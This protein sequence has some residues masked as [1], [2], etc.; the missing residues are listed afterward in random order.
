VFTRSILTAGPALLASA[1]CWL[2][3]CVPAHAG[4]PHR[5]LALGDSDAFGFQFRSY[6]PGVPASTFTGYAAD[7]HAERPALALV[8]YGCV[9]ESTVSF[10]QGPC[11][12]KALG[13]QLHD[14]YTGSQLKAALAFLLTHPLR[15][16]LI[17]LTLWGNDVNTFVAGCAGDL[18]CVQAGAQA[19]IAKFSA[20]LT[21]I[22]ASL[23]IA[24]GPRATIVLTGPYDPN[25]QPLARLTHPLYLALDAAMRTAAARLRVRYA[26]LF[27]AF[28]SDAALCN[29]TLLCSDGDAH[30][31]DAGYRTIADLILD[32]ASF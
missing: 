9:G 5:Y 4:A 14:D 19:A 24:A 8:N 10:L 20:R 6:F 27:S 12:Y 16:D 26:A 7:L 23:R 17:T 15:S 22:L 13:Q 25:P 29:L 3:L 18:A 2:S 30:P 32:V 31:S 21:A 1:L 28:D 11:P